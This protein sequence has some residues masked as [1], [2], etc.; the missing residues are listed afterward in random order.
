MQV[1]AR[2]DRIT[3]VATAAVLSIFT[4]DSLCARIFR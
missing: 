4:E 1:S 2:V 3:A